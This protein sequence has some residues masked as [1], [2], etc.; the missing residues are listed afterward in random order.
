ML[1]LENKYIDLLLKRC[2]NLKKSTSLFISYDKTCNDFVKK[3][4]L[5]AKELGYSDIYEDCSDIFNLKNKLMNSSL[6]EIENDP[7]YDKSI[8]DKHAEKKANFLMLETEFPG[9]MDGVDS[10]KLGLAKS[11]NR[12]TR[13]L[14]KHLETTYQIPWCIAAIPNKIWADKIFPNSE[15]SYKELFLVICKMCMVDREDPIKS[16]NEFMLKSKDD[17]DWLN[18]LEIKSLHYTNEIGTDL[19]IEMPKEYSWSGL[20]DDLKNEMIV[21]MPSYEIF[22]SPN[23]KKTEGIVV[24]SKPLYYGGGLIENFYLKFKDGK[25]IDFNAE[26]GHELLKSIIESDE[27]SC[28]LGEVALV[29]F[30][31]P[32]SNTGLVFGTTLFDENASCHLALGNGFPTTIPNGANLSREELLELGIN[33]SSNHVDFMIGTSDLKIEA[34]TKNG[35]QLIFK[36]GNFISH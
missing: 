33:S 17:I 15:D 4:V 36:N 29:N 14:F 20:T 18:S 10:K 11:I 23:Y 7:Y 35:K 5:R 9:V 12:K 6:D 1:E 13:P 27:N 25:V 8:W 21:N 22:A 32:I 3:L 28:Y 26:K 30:D 19:K 24:S 16:W 2:L 34:E 31:S